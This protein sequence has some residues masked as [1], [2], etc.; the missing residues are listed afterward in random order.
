MKPG[1]VAPIED[2]PFYQLENTGTGPMVMM[3]TR[4]GPRAANKHITYETE[5]D[6][7]GIRPKRLRGETVDYEKDPAGAARRK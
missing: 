2:G 5:Q 7:T 4:I 6:V 3:G 1:M